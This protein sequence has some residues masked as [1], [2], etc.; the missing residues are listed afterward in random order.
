M[1]TR[2]RR[3]A[4]NAADELLKQMQ[5]DTL[6]VDVFHIAE[7]LGVSVHEKPDVKAG[8]SGA[9]LKTGNNFAIAYAT[10]ISSRG[11]QRFSIG[12]ELGHL[13]IP[14]HA[15]AL[16]P[17]GTTMHESRAG[18]PLSD[19]RERE[20]D[21]FSA[22]LLMPQNL[23]RSAMLH[24]GDGLSAILKLAKLCGTSTLAT[25]IRYTRLTDEPMAIV[26]SEASTMRYAFLSDALKEF[27][28]ITW[29]QRNSPLPPVPTACFNQDHGNIILRQQAECETPMGDWFGGDHS[30]TLREE[31][32]GLGQYGQTLTILT[33]T[34]SVE[35]DEAEDELQES[36]TPRFRR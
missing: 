24:A 15:D 17:A 27:R 33:S 7:R 25:A 1:D 28:R 22:N 26:V 23:F 2:A 34:L 10:H 20:A 13:H 29:P 16:L 6:P 36:W 32:M 30:A 18:D 31:I 8:V 3:T 19:T 35:E 12:H 11:F 14:G 9:L 4:A 21:E 5:I